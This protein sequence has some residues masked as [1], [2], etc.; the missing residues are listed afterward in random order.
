MNTKQVSTLQQRCRIPRKNPQ[1]IIGHQI[2]SCVNNSRD[3]LRLSVSGSEA[4][5]QK[6]GGDQV[7]ISVRGRTVGKV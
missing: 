6:A 1:C 5:K 2:S 4:R 7:G 3:E